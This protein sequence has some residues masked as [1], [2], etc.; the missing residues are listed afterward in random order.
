MRAMHAPIGC[1]LYDGLRQW[2]LW[3]MLGWNDIRQRYRRSYLG[4][5]WMTISM[6]VL[7][8]AL[9]FIYS[10]LFHTR[11]ETYLPFLTLGF[12][13]WGLISA[14]VKES[15]QAFFEHESLIKQ[16][17]VP[18]STYVLCVV[19]RNFVVLL[20]T[21]VIFVPFS[22]YFGRWLQP[23]AVLAVPGL[24]LLV[25]NLVWV[26]LVLAI[27]NTRFRD[28]SQIVETIL[29]IAIFATPIMWPAS[30]L[31]EYEF[32]AKMN[33]IFHWI[34]LV[35]APLLGESPSPSSWI[36][37]IALLGSGT[38]LAMLLFRRVER[39]IVYWV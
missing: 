36:V 7:V 19:W 31:G 8:G 35:R 39:R 18:F 13:I 37:A 24:M 32:V 16:M 14:C 20:H 25:L 5:F 29:Q 17:K 22:L 27:L 10:H 11:I 28:V 2:R 4:P 21:I 9:G 1:D 3:T 12:V 6:S 23:V 26:G 34:E 33:P 15:C 38:L 30:A